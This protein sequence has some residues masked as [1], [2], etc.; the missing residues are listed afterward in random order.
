[1]WSPRLPE[2]FVTVIIVTPLN[3]TVLGDNSAYLAS[4]SATVI[5]RVITMENEHTWNVYDISRQRAIDPFS[6]HGL[7]QIQVLYYI[8]CLSV[9]C[10]THFNLVPL[11]WIRVS[12]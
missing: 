5:Y 8:T 2:P 3:K 12:R 11:G 10:N 7:L 1:M 4:K 9:L 6:W